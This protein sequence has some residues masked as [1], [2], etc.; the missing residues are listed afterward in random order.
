M[1]HTL[2]QV[3]S[4]APVRNVKS[5]KTCFVASKSLD[6]V[7]ADNPGFDR[8]LGHPLELVPVRNP[9]TPMGPDTPIR[10]RLLFRGKPLAGAR[11]SFVPRGT[12]LQE[13]FDPRYE[14]RSDGK[15]EASFRPA[16]GNYYL[17][18]AHHH[19]AAAT[20]PGY[21][22]IKYSATL[23]VLVPQT[24]PCCGD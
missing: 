7:P 5:A 14:R 6:R 3:A 9:V 15:G 10:V 2:D 21:K 4:Y 24:C 1:A 19:D 18:V 22:G 13:G 17:V 20:G 16:E 8:P 23:V 11:I 12:A